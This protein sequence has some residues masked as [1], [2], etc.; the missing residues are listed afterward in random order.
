MLLKQHKKLITIIITFV[1]KYWL[2]P[3]PLRFSSL[4]SHRGRCPNTREKDSTLKA[5]KFWPNWGMSYQHAVFWNLAFCGKTVHI[6]SNSP[7]V[8]WSDSHNEKNKV[9]GAKCSLTV[10]RHPHSKAFL[11]PTVLTFIS[12][13]FV[14]PTVKITPIINKLQSDCPPEETLQRD[15]KKK[16]QN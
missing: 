8:Y 16:K 6:F 1:L 9:H 11:K 2:F 15:M 5:Y 14:D 7:T 13:F 10:M 12:T 3:S 4:F